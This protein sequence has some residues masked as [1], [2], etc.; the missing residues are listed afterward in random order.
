MRWKKIAKT[1]WDIID[2][3]DTAGDQYKPEI[4]GYY[5]FVCNEVRKRFKYIG[6]D[7]YILRRRWVNQP[8]KYRKKE[9][10]KEPIKA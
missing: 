5:K 10:P 8:R 1:L 2:N 3:I 4:N 7:G 9:I 6:S